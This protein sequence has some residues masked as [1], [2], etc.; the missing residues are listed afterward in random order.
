MLLQNSLSA[1][2][3]SAEPLREAAAV[4]DHCE[5]T[6]TNA[7]EPRIPKII[8]QIWKNKDLSTY[9]LEASREQW[10]RHFDSDY[11]V[12]LW[13]ED[14]VV[15]LI[16]T[17][18]PW[19]F[20]TYQN[21]KYDIQRADIAR[22]LVVHAEGG[23][24]ADLDAYPITANASDTVP[25]V[26]RLGYQAV[27]APMT[28]DGGVSNHFFMAE[29]D[30]E[31]LLWALHEAKKRATSAS[32]RFMPPYVA[33]LWSTGPIMITT[34]MN[35]YAWAYNQVHNGK[36]VAILQDRYSHL[37]IHHAAGRYWQGFD[38]RFLNFIGDNAENSL[39]QAAIFL[40]VAAIALL[41]FRLWR[42]RSLKNHY[43][44]IPLSQRGAESAV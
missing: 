21:Y 38:G 7:S 8:H 18:Y 12:K 3:V 33:V 15:A 30:S 29:K 17:S 23:I 10:L 16:E 5:P 2:R 32:S 24:Y 37:L 25:C 34:V 11:D 41:I 44:A 6:A 9:S 4:I 35:E 22:L 20:P 42:R 27:F 14:D 13:T 39:F 31:F 28:G 40:G 43:E 36:D 19:L 1:K 26:Q